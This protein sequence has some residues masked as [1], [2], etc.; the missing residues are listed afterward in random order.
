MTSQELRLRVIKTGG[1]YLGLSDGK[2]YKFF[3]CGDRV[4]AINFFPAN[5]PEG[6]YQVHQNSGEYGK[7]TEPTAEALAVLQERDI[8]SR[9]P[10]GT[11]ISGTTCMCARE[12]GYCADECLHN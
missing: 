4:T 11:D 10:L 5:R 6:W 12:E 1:G 8:K 3:R 7:L 2:V 9:C